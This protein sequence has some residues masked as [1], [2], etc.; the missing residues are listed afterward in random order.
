MEG[1]WIKTRRN[2]TDKYSSAS[3]EFTYLLA[4]QVWAVQRKYSPFLPYQTEIYAKSEED[5]L[6]LRTKARKMWWISKDFLQVRS[7]LG[8][9]I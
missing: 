4:F 8:V 1:F 2:V 9:Q 6:K 5:F 7:H 3:E